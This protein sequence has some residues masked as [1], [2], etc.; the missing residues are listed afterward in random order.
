M[1]IFRIALYNLPE[2]RFA[3]NA[4][5]LARCTLM[6]GTYSRELLNDS[7]FKVH[8][9]VKFEVDISRVLTDFRSHHP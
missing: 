2:G 7:L 8:L 6:K 3:K 1:E 5:F 9:E 4:H